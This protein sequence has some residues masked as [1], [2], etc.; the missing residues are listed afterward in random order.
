MK[1]GAIIKSV[2]VV[3][4][5]SLF[6]ITSH[7]GLAFH[8]NEFW[9]D[10]LVRTLAQQDSVKRSSVEQKSEQQNIVIVDI[11]DKSMRAMEPIAGKWP[12]PRSI[13]ASLI[14]GLSRYQPKAI[15]FDI[16]F[17]VQDIYRPDDDAYFSETISHHSM[18]YL[19]GAVLTDNA[20]TISLEQYQPF[21]PI[22]KLPE[23]SSNDNASLTLP[24]I[25]PAEHWQVGSINF[26]PDRDGI[27]RY[28]NVRQTVSGWSWLSL[29]AL[30]AR[31]SGYSLP[32]KNKIRLRWLSDDLRPFESLSYSDLFAHLDHP[33]AAK[34]GQL[35]ADKIVIIGSS[36]TGLF[37][38]RATPVAKEYYA[39]FILAT[40][41]DNL[42]HQNYYRDIDA[43]WIISLGI[44][45]IA[46]LSI[47]AIR[48]TYY[49][50]LLTLYWPFYLGI[51]LGLL[52][53]SYLSGVTGYILPIAYLIVYLGFSLLVITLVRG[54]SEFIQRQRLIS[55]FSRFMDPR[56][57]SQLIDN[58]QLEVT[59]QS[60]ICTITVLFSDIRG[61]TTLSEQNSAEDI[62]DLLNQYFS[63]QVETIFKYGGTLDKFIGDAVMAFWGA[64]VTDH[65]QS[66]NA[67]KAAQEMVENLKQFRQQLPESLR[68]FDVGIGLHTGEAVVGMIGSEKRY[69]YTAI[70][71]TVNLASRIEGLTKE[72]ARILV[73]Q[74]CVENC[75]QDFKW[76]SMGSFNVKGRTEPVR[77]FS[78]EG[79]QL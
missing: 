29:P 23:T 31:Q 28:Y 77:I 47:L 70:G 26:Y 10:I 66:D 53:L 37:D 46:G 35:F 69:D 78:L 65:A 8:V 39:V 71:D 58:Q 73:S 22:E 9:N 68:Q 38:S 18:V 25:V 36:A 12:W 5:T 64:P 74:S 24:W 63:L 54:F 14:E 44:F 76:E 75:K 19:A 50:N 55:L 60:R 42:I 48:V 27:G 13:H 72:R 7:T 21:L 20:Q 52:G 6:V 61:F 30:V 43:N 33:D 15:V 2:I 49:R 51:S 11:D 57:V 79:S 4:M 1:Q 59:T 67:V 40:A 45:L 41:L 56:V 62:V 17:S 3:V 32:D 16:L 34:H